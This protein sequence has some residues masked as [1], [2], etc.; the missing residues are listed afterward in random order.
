M[1]P[2][3]S[4]L[5]APGVKAATWSTQRVSASWRGTL[6]TLKISPPEMSCPDQAPLRFERAGKHAVWIHFV[7][8]SSYL[9]WWVFTGTFYGVGG[10]C[11]QDVP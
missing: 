1:V 7:I 5:R 2:A 11:S 4:S 8:F 6:P 10:C 9:V 3:V